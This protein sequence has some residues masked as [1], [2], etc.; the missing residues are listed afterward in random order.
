MGTILGAQALGWETLV[1]SLEPGK[2]ADLAIV[3]LPNRDAADPHELLFDSAKP[4]VGCY[5]RGAK[6][7]ACE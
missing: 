7:P 2:Q 3:A 5:C 1:G 6:V 4:V